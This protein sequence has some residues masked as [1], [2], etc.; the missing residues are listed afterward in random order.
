MSQLGVGQWICVRFSRSRSICFY[1]FFLNFIFLSAI[2]KLTVA[3]HR[4]KTGS[5]G[6]QMYL[7]VQL[8]LISIKFWPIDRSG[9]CT[10]RGIRDITL[11]FGRVHIGCIMTSDECYFVCGMV[12]CDRIGTLYL[13]KPTSRIIVSTPR[14]VALVTFEH[15]VL[16]GYLTVV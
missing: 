2:S 15:C 11:V 16:A 7:K 12:V 1:I 9:F 3:I 10:K 6:Y 4:L 5:N 8:S 14:R 13:C